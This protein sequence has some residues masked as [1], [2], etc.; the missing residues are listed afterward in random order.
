MVPIWNVRII[1]FRAGISGLESNLSEEQEAKSPP[2]HSSPLPPSW[3]IGPSLF[4][5]AA[6]AAKQSIFRFMYPKYCGDL[7]P[8]RYVDMQLFR[9]F[10]S[11]TLRLLSLSHVTL[12]TSLCAVL[13]C[14]SCCHSRCW[15]YSSQSNVY[16]RPV[17]S[18]GACLF[19]MT[20]NQ[21]SRKRLDHS[22]WLL[23]KW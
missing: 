8:A 9:N 14:T 7:L 10:H 12:H 20:S 2:H 5:V 19:M 1:P 13:G 6:T 21:D 16:Y 18:F 17:S 22:S 15:L 3:Q 4:N 11:P 23:Y